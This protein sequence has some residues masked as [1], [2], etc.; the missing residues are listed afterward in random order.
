VIQEVTMLIWLF[1]LISV[2]LT[3]TGISVIEGYPT[4]SCEEFV[5]YLLVGFGLLAMLNVGRHTRD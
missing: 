3:M 2:I 1:W 5:G 4:N